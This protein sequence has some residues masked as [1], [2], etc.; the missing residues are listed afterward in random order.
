MDFKYTKLIR[1]EIN[2]ILNSFAFFIN[3]L[4][5]PRLI[6]SFYNNSINYSHR[7]A[8]DYHALMLFGMIF[9]FQCCVSIGNLV[10]VHDQMIALDG[11]P[12]Q[13]PQYYL[14]TGPWTSSESTTNLIKKENI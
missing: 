1:N 3:N 6:H 13:S 14:L 10:W 5:S 9:N 4:T 12:I 11:F 7:L 8:V 2:L